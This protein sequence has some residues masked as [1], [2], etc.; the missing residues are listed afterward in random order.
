MFSFLNSYFDIVVRLLVYLYNRLLWIDSHSGTS[1]SSGKNQSEEISV[2]FL[3]YYIFMQYLY[4]AS[5]TQQSKLQKL[6]GAWGTECP[7]TS[8]SAG[9]LAM[10]GIQ[11]EAKKNVY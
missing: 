5:L 8:F 9:N 3:L 4:C 6:G 11:H 2:L 7:N 10:C 1:A